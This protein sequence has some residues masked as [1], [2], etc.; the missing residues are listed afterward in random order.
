MWRIEVYD[1]EGYDWMLLRVDRA[2]NANA[3]ALLAER[4]ARAGRAVSVTPALPVEARRRARDH[5]DRRGGTR[6]AR[7]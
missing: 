4:H 3:A 5:H 7:R 2:P 1:V 6:A